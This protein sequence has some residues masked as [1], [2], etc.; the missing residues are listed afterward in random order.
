MKWKQKEYKNREMMGQKRT[1]TKFLWF[2]KTLN[3]ETRWLEVA[4]WSEEYRQFV[5]YA[6]FNYRWDAISGWIE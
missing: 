6:G 5:A 3:S 1:V 2:P 4:T